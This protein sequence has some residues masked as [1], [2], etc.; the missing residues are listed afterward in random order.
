MT[1]GVHRFPKGAPALT[2]AAK[3]LDCGDEPTTVS[4]TFERDGKTH[5]IVRDLA[6]PN[7]ATLDGQ[8]GE[9]KDILALLTGGELSTSDRVENLV[10]LFRATHLFSQDRQALTEEIAESCQ[11]PG[12]LVSRMLAS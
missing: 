2:K 4:L 8:P 6:E 11:L 12:D 3:H 10:A 1:G 5:T 9:R 7:K